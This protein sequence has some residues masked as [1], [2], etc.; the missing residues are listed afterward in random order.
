MSYVYLLLLFQVVTLHF[1]LTSGIHKKFIFGLNWRSW[2]WCWSCHCWSWLLLCIVGTYSSKTIDRHMS[3][4]I[5]CTEIDSIAT[6]LVC[7]SVISVIGDHNISAVCYTWLVL[8][9]LCFDA[10][11][12]IAAVFWVSLTVIF[13]WSIKQCKTE[14]FR[15]YYWMIY[16]LC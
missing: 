2:S 11:I 10:F 9:A 8:M 4:V 6:V 15:P 7:V 1:C 5:K 14:Y 13:C 3:C 16:Q 12:I